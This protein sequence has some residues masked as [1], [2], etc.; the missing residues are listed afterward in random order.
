MIYNTNSQTQS[1]TILDLTTNN[2]TV[3]ESIHINDGSFIT[4]TVVGYSP[5]NWIG[6]P[7]NAIF[8]L[9]KDP[10]SDSQ[11]GIGYIRIPSGATITLCTLSN[12]GVEI[13]PSTSAINVYTSSI[14][15]VPP[16]PTNIITLYGSPF[17]SAINV[18]PVLVVEGHTYNSIGTNGIPPHPNTTL[19]DHSFV[20]LKVS[21]TLTTGGLRIS[22]QYQTPIVS[23]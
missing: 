21:E 12:N 14:P 16:T 10:M 11:L 5:T 1:A 3:N 6:A 9:M 4:S 23:G 13:L 2:L 22:I 20:Q 7:P 15:S 8:P 19:I 17:A 18:S